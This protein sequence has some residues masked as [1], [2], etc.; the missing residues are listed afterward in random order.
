MRAFILVATLFFSF[1]IYGLFLTQFHPSVLVDELQLKNPSGFYDY[2][3]Q[4]DVHTTISQGSGSPSEVIRAAQESGNDFLIL[5]DVND[6]TQNYSAEG[7]HQRT[8]TLV[9]G[10]Y[11]YVDSQLIFFDVYHNSPIDSFGKAQVILADQLSQKSS[12]AKKDLLILAHPFKHGSAWNGPTPSGLDGFELLNLKVV[13][14]KAWQQS[15]LSFLWSILIYPFNSQL[16]L[17]RL[18]EDPK[19]E[20][21]FWDSNLKR[22][23][24]TAIA[25]AD[26]T[27]RT[28]SIGDFSLKFPSYQV[29]FGLFSNHVLLNSEL[30]GNFDGDRKKI[31]TALKKAQFYMSFDALANPKGFN[32]FME[33]HE[34]TYAMGADVHLSPHLTLK[35]HLP[36]KPIVDFEVTIMRDGV[37]IRTFNSQDSKFEITSKGVYKVVVRVIPTFPLPDGKRWLTWIYSN[38]FYVN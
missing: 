31:L 6:F 13:W 3:G 14:Q 24:F 20:L 30:T 33:D 23:K 32:T 21:E 18:Y 37:A 1:F 29:S 8:L 38:P 27:A 15:K 22:R 26:A 16:S 34:H 4:I 2:R 25:G 17:L 19:E 12:E 7:Y 36:Q 5:T 11:N 28:G 10:Q 35:T 9:A